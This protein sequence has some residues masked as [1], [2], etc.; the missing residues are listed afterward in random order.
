MNSL[1]KQNTYRLT[2]EVDRWVTAEAKR[3][4]V[5]KNAVVQMALAETM[6]ERMGDR[7]VAANDR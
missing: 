7:V 2:P 6:R 5:S 4:G 1:R 3:L